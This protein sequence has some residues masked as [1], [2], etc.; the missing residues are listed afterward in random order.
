MGPTQLHGLAQVADGF[1][2]VRAGRGQTSKVVVGSTHM[3][4]IL[5]QEMQPPV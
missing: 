3:G 1:I 5:S 4:M 2:V